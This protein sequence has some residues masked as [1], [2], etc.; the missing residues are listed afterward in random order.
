MWAR[1]ASRSLD[2]N[3]LFDL[4]QREAQSSGLRYETEDRR[5]LI[6]VEAIASCC[7]AWGRDNPRS[8]IETQRL[9]T[10]ASLY[11]DLPDE[12]AVPSHD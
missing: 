3:D 9:P 5:R 12:Q 2:R 4:L 6:P 10:D 8:L 7:A 11:R 1:S